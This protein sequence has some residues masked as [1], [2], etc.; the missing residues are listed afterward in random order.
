LFARRGI[1]L[2]AC[3]P[4]AAFVCLMSK[5]SPCA[6]SYRDPSSSSSSRR[7]ANLGLLVYLRAVG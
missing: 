2:G 7:I 5:Q 3:S 1:I 4:G 6:M